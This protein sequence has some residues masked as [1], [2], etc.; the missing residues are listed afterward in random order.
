[1]AENWSKFFRKLVDLVLQRSSEL[2]RLEEMS[3]AEFLGAARRV[4]L[5][6]PL[7]KTEILVLF[8]YKD[9]L[10]KA[11]IWQIK[12]RN[13]GKI[14]RMLAEILRE[15]LVGELAELRQFADFREPIII[16]IPISAA[17][18]KARGYNQTENLAREMARQDGGLPANGLSR[19]RP[20][21]HRL[22]MA[23]RWQ[24]GRN[25]E[26][27][28]DIL[29]KTKETPPQSA[30]PRALRLKNLKGCFAVT[31]PEKIR[32]RNIILLD[33]VTTTGAT[34]EEAA[35]TL[36]RAGARKV[37]AIVIAH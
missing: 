26:T 35:S 15:E 34:L 22:A 1:M 4:R 23:G 20:A 16:P 10:V 24:A 19:R 11:A 33:D 7:Q 18:R 21:C 8:N 12:Y 25:F 32:G 9:P 27:L 31:D 3:A 36:R 6:A 30:L 14:V 5:A 17:R 13:H 28:T 37:I 29:I 2:A